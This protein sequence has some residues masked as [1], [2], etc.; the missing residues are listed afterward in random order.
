MKRA[1]GST[2]LIGM[3]LA[4]TLVSGPACALAGGGEV[5]L[6]YTGSSSEMTAAGSELFSRD[7]NGLPGDTFT[8]RIV[9]VNDSEEVTEFFTSA[10]DVTAKG[11]DD[12]LDRIGF[13]VSESSEAVLFDGTLS[14]AE[15]AEPLSLGLVE[16]GDTVE[17]DYEV[18]IPTELTSEYADTVVG[19]N[20]GIAA[21]EV[22]E[23]PVATPASADPVEQEAQGTKLGKTGDD[24]FWLPAA[25]MAGAGALIVG[26]IVARRGLALFRRWR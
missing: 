5:S 4:A 17:V 12:T 23:E 9:V 8:G 10:K 21:V 25:L 20:V 16:P 2:A 3:V 11:P 14:E 22:P 26:C 13:T 7:E 18:R 1:A 19:L 24:A 6:S 15:D